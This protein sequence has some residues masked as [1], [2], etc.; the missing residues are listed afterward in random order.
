[1]HKANS[2]IIITADDG[3]CY[4]M[5]GRPGGSCRLHVALSC[6]RPAVVNKSMSQM[7]TL[8]LALTTSFASFT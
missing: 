8:L 1:M 2:A 7:A 4:L 3:D 6:P 5:E